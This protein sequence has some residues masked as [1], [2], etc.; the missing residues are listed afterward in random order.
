MCTAI[1]LKTKDSY[2]GRTLDLDRNYGE[3]I[4]ITPKQ[5]AFNFK[6]GETLNSHYSIIGM[7][8]E[9]NGFPLYYDA[10]NEKG[11]CIA[12][13]NFPDSAYFPPYKHTPYEIAPFEVIPYILSKCSNISEVKTL[14]NKTV[15]ANI[16]FSSSLPAS[17]LH[18]IISDKTHCITVEC[19]ESGINICENN[20]GVLTNEPPFNFH[21]TNINSYLNLSAYEPFNSFSKNLVLRPFSKGMGAI[22]L[23]GDNSSVSRFIR[24]AFIKFNSVSGDSEYESVNRFFHILNSVENVKGT[25]YT[26]EEK[27]QITVYTC[28]INADKGIYY[29]TTYDNKSL[30]AVNLFKEDLNGKALISYPL[31][32][33]RKVNFQ[34]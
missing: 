11:L 32:T 28:C 16:N 31:I 20:I 19:T 18:W 29:Y 25:V 7:A 5:F 4:I 21:I 24:A 27:C 9:E 6:N 34:N 23:P 2:F 10:V 12:G 33:E 8:T 1:T 22:G 17:P 3:K 30:N 13:L 15:I 14:F 26:A